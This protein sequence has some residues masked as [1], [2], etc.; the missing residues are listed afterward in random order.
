LTADPLDPARSKLTI[1][2]SSTDWHRPGACT[3]H[4]VW[5]LR[6]PS[7]LKPTEIRIARAAVEWNHGGYTSEVVT[8]V[9]WMSEQRAAAVVAAEE[10]PHGNLE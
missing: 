1:V 10:R 9:G 8:L 4:N 6:W 7:F 3:S 2:Q 5:S